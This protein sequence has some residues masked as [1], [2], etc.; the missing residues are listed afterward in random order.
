MYGK[1]GRYVRHSRKRYDAD[2]YWKSAGSPGYIYFS[3][4][5]SFL[6]RSVLPRNWI[7]YII[8]YVAY[9][10]LGRGDNKLRIGQAHQMLVTVCPSKPGFPNGFGYRLSLEDSPVQILVTLLDII[11]YVQRIILSE[12]KVL[13]IEFAI[14]GSPYVTEIP[15]ESPPNAS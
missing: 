10:S 1:S 5:G 7:G 6:G 11:Q 2:P 12:G 13:R 9:P 8:A 14:G 15:S 3:L 4:L